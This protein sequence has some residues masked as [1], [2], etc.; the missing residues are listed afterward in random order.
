M[1]KIPND[2]AFQPDPVHHP[3]H[4]TRGGLECIDVIEALDLPFH[5]ASYQKRSAGE[6]RVSDAPA[7]KPVLRQ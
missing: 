1:A 6:H 7:E 2:R 4:Y 3:S 5:K